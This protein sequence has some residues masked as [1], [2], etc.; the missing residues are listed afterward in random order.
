[1]LLDTAQQIRRPPPKAQDDKSR[2]FQLS[3]Q[4][5]D[6]RDASLLGTMI[7]VGR[8]VLAR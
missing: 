7:E 1:M 8:Y 6:L 4:K 3:R 5:S 2:G